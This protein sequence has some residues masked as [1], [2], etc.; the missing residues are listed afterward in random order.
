MRLLA[1]GRCTLFMQGAMAILSMLLPLSCWATLG[2]NAASVL[3]DQAQMKGTVHSVDN[4]TYVL[5]EI[6]APSGAK[7][8]EYVS[9]AG[10]V[11]A[12]TWEGQFPPNFQQLLG[13]YYQQ[14]QQAMAQQASAQPSGEQPTRRRRGPVMI[15]T[16]G[17]VFSQGGHQRSFHGQTYIPQLVPQGVQTSD[18]R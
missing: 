11:F 6:T 17:L 12:V 14:L 9:P 8:R 7:V 2:D 18:I 10:A 15:E 1:I 4:R 5:H 16:P 3:T 13:P